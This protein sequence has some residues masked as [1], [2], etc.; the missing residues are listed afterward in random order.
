MY[1]E[2]R[3]DLKSGFFLFC[4]GGGERTLWEGLAG[5]SGSTLGGLLGSGYAVT[6]LPRM[7]GCRAGPTDEG[8]VE[9]KMVEVA[10][11]S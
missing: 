5:D 1:P 10:R 7:P 3:Q 2:N 4:D 9:G 8:Q 6:P 11:E